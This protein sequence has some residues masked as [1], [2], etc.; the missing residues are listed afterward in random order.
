MRP[1]TSKE[2]I[3]LL[4]RLTRDNKH[5]VN[6]Y[7]LC[8]G[9]VFETNDTHHVGIKVDIRRRILDWLKENKISQRSVA[10]ALRY[11]PQDFNAFL[12]GYEPLPLTRLEELMWIMESDN[13]YT[14]GEQSETRIIKQ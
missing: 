5:E 11:R 14:Q 12:N 3:A 6:E 8:D 10:I 4:T 13:I 2:K 7:E 9:E 1:M